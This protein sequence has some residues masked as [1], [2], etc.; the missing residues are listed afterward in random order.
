MQHEHD[1][2]MVD[3]RECGRTFDLARQNYYDNLCP[4]CM[5]KENPER[6][7]PRCT[8]CD[9]PIPPEK[10]AYKTV[11]GAARDPSTVRLPVHEGCKPDSRGAGHTITGP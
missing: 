6:T 10:R 5:E 1:P 2:D 8:E 4:S 9:D 11:R 7:W 3:C